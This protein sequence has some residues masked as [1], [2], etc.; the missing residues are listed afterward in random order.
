MSILLEEMEV[1]LHFGQ[2]L[3]LLRISTEFP[4]KC[5]LGLL[6]TTRKELL[7]YARLK[8]LREETLVLQR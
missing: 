1:A 8:V 6:S 3:D 4:K 7:R 5:S 2:S